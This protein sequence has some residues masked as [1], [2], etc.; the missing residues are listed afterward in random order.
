MG[1]TTILHA[2]DFHA[3]H[4]LVRQWDRAIKQAEHTIA[5]L[6]PDYLASA[7]SSA[8][9][10]AAVSRDPGGEHGTLIPVHVRQCEVK[11]LLRQIIAVD[12]VG[13]TEL[14][15]LARLQTE[16]QHSRR[17]PLSAPVFPIQPP[18]PK[19]EHFPGTPAPQKSSFLFSIPG[20]LALLIV[21]IL[22][23]FL[24]RILQG[25]NAFTWIGLLIAISGSSEQWRFSLRTPFFQRV[26]LATLSTLLTLLLIGLPFHLWTFHTQ[27]LLSP[28]EAQALY[29]QITSRTPSLHDSF[30]E[31]PSNERR[32]DENETCVFTQG[33]YVLS[34]FDHVLPECYAET[35]DVSNLAFEVTMTIV[36]GNGGGIAFRADRTVPLKEYRFY[37][38]NEDTHYNLVRSTDIRTAPALVRHWS[39]NILICLCRL[40]MCY[41]A[42]SSTSG[43]APCPGSSILMW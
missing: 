10:A 1:Y 9:W 6:S 22:P 36:K 35:L 5:L 28:L 37:A 40:V 23:G 15:V 25:I 41:G 32:W 20:H 24:L 8:E 16:V 3:G 39:A 30:Q 19:P 42:N 11:G 12:L 38:S 2:W 13:C 29:D 34:T 27:K 43:M 7:S 4:N 18:R 31:H 33:A 14:Q 21:T 17:K 26:W